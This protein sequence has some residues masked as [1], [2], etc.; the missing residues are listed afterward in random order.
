[1]Q[2]ITV[3]M[4]LATVRKELNQLEEKYQQSK[5]P[6]KEWEIVA[7]GEKHGNDI[8]IYRLQES[9]R[10]KSES[11]PYSSMTWPGHSF[12]GNHEFIHSVRRL[13]DGEVFSVGDRI[14]PN[15]AHHPIIITQFT[16]TDN[17]IRVHNK[18]GYFLSGE[19]YWQ[20]MQKLPAPVLTTVDGVEIYKD[21]KYW[22]VESMEEGYIPEYY[23]SENNKTL[24]GP[25]FSTR[26]AAETYILN[27]LRLL[28]LNDVK[29]V[30]DDIA[31]PV[32]AAHEMKARLTALVKQK[33][34]Q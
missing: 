8:H 32:P 15:D 26:E 12:N 11:H 28:S 27:N 5:A 16:A 30:I 7:Y 17:V 20:C 25:A 31:G 10:Y 18:E 2:E 33:L 13:S 22:V 24:R 21:E 14:K 19:Q 34:N 4:I 1:M 9:G 6:K 3:E 29:E 23:A